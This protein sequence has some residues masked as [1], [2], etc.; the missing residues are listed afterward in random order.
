M[1][2][3]HTCYRVL[4]LDRSLDFYTNTLGLARKGDDDAD[5]TPP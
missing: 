5:S 3:V 1:K 2:Y 4:D